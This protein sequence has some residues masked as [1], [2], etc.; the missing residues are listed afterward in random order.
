MKK[1][2]LL[3]MGL[4]AAGLVMAAAPAHPQGPPAVLA[5]GV[6]PGYGVYAAAVTPDTVLALLPAETPA[7]FLTVL[8]AY[9]KPEQSRLDILIKPIDAREDSVFI[10][11]VPVDFYLRC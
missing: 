11:P 7:R 9:E 6:L 5:L 2:M 4:V 10:S 8:V 1:L 3:L